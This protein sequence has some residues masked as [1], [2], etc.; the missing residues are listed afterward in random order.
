M[1]VVQCGS[2]DDHSNVKKAISKCYRSDT[3]QRYKRGTCPRQ[4]QNIISGINT[5]CH[6]L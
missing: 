6:V 5:R 3:V 2:I 1:Y 4:K